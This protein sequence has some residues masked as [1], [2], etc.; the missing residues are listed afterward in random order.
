VENLPQNIRGYTDIFYSVEPV[1]RPRTF[2]GTIIPF[3]WR[4]FVIWCGFCSSEAAETSSSTPYLFQSC[5][6]CQFITQT[7]SVDMSP[8]LSAI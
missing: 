7:L 5:V 3:T 4:R 2:Y 8:I 1:V 6:V